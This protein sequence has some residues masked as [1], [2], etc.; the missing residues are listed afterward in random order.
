MIEAERDNGEAARAL[1]LALRAADLDRRRALLA[2]IS[3]IERRWGLA[4][5]ASEGP[6]LFRLLGEDA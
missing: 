5:Y 6:A 2:E 4:Q 3:A 1:L